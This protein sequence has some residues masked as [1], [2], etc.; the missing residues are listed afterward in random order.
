MLLIAGSYCTE[1]MEAKLYPLL[2]YDSYHFLPITFAREQPM[3]A[4]IQ[5]SRTLTSQLLHL[6]QFH[7]MPKCVVW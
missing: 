7:P 1:M 6:A 5:L 3:T 4:E 2:E